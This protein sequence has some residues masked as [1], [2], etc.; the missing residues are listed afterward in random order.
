VGQVRRYRG[1]VF[2]AGKRAPTID[3]GRLRH[4]R[5]KETCGLRESVGAGLLANRDSTATVRVT[6]M[7][8]S[9]ASRRTRWV[10]F[11]DIAGWCFRGQARSY[12]KPGRLRNLRHKETCGLRE[13]VGA[14]LLAN[15]YS[16]ATVRVTGMTVRQQAGSYKWAVS[17]T[18][19]LNGMTRSPASRLLP[20]GS[21]VGWMRLRSRFSPRHKKTHQTVGSFVAVA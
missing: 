13:S 17:A 12:N 10:R 2:F 14:G 20:F 3:P 18:A 11:G 5:H 7:T 19:R 4:L 16:T 1:L 15:R 6:G 9:P 21:V 8:R